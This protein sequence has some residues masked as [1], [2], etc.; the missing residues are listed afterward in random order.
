[1]RVFIQ[2]FVLVQYFDWSSSVPIVPTF[3]ITLLRLFTVYQARK[4]PLPSSG[5][6][7]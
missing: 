6:L 3:P 5:P 2:Q 4:I 1:M 7:Q